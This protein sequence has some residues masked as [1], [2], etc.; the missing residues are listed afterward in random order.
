LILPLVVA[1]GGDLASSSL[2]LALGSAFQTP[3]YA[4]QAR[5]PGAVASV[6]PFGNTAARVEDACVAAGPGLAAGERADGIGAHEG[7]LRRGREPDVLV[8]PAASTAPSVCESVPKP[9]LAQALRA[10]DSCCHMQIPIYL[11]SEVRVFRASSAQVDALAAR[12]PMHTLV[13]VASKDDLLAALP[14]AD[15]AVVWSFP[16]KWYALAPRLRHVFTPAAG[17]ERIQP[18]PDGAV[19]LHFGRFHGTLMAESLLAMM[20]FMNRRFGA[21][22]ANQRL[23]RW[24]G[25]AYEGT[26]R[27]AGQSAL[28]VGYGNIGRKM[29]ALLSAASVRVFGLKRDVGHGGEGA[30][31]L[32]AREELPS[33]VALADHIVCVL[34]RDTATD[35]VLDVAAFAHMKQSAFIYNLGRGNAVDVRALV[36]ALGSGRI[37]GA[38]LDVWPEEPLPAESPFWQ[39]PNLYLTPHASAIYDDYLDLYFDELAPIL[40]ELP[41]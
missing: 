11:N 38:F 4:A 29:A 24:D 35:H 2:S 6:F 25:R 10:R 3:S 16:A 8:H 36:A 19:Q 31:Q 40:G 14:Q 37:A 13:P 27:L 21:A 22:V 34:P 23:H 33:A 32:F 28:I 5:T 15:A 17:R 12:L 1:A 39:V 20:L 30:E 18:S 9:Q 26:R 7:G 41:A